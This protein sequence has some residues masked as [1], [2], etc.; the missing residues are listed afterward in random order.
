MRRIDAVLF[1]FGGV[2]TEPVMHLF[3]RVYAPGVPARR[4][5]E[6]LLGDYGAVGSLHPWHRLERGEITLH[7][8]ERLTRRLAAEL[9]VPEFQVPLTSTVNIPAIRTSM[10]HLSDRLQRAGIATAIVTNNIREFYGWRDTVDAER[11]FDVIV[12]SS[13]VGMRKP[14]PTIFELTLELLGV[15]ASRAVMLDDMEENV[16]GAERAGLL[17]ILVEPDERPAVR[18]VEYLAGLFEPGFSPE[19]TL[20]TVGEP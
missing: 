6:I 2:I 3:D 18:I 13:Q 7:E 11:R 19:R 9:G 15:S 20:A 16:K 17:G 14:D 10:L 5:R 4:M 1:D 8:Y 12:D